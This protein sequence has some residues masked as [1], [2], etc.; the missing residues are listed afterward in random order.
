MVCF[1]NC[2]SEKEGIFHVTKNHQLSM[3][4]GI[5]VTTQ[6]I[7]A[8]CS[9]NNLEPHFEHP[10]LP[11]QIGTMEIYSAVVIGLNI[12]EYKSHYPDV[13]QTSLSFWKYIC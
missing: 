12:C 10:Y 5:S 13:A 7:A 8:V 6:L 11:S 2:T 3:P 1:F 9:R 4:V